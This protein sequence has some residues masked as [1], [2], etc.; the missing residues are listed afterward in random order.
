[1]VRRCVL[2]LAVCLVV[3]SVSV[4]G[5][6]TDLFVISVK[7]RQK[8]G[9][10]LGVRKGELGLGK[11][12]FGAVYDTKDADDRW[13]VLGTQIKSSVVGGYLAYDAAGKDP[14]VFLVAKP[15]DG[16]EWSID[17]PGKS[18]E[19]V[20]GTIRAAAGPMKGWVLEIDAD[21]QPVLAKEPSK[22]LEVER[23]FEHK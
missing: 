1:M 9:N 7:E 5:I 11:S 20:R 4:A 12:T 22:K 6:P 14:K 16:T 10:Y 8:K 17:E 19:G 23:V 3:G 13:Y 2:S 15:G 18:R 21:G